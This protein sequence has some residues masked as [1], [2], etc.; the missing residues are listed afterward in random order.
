M[1]VRLWG[2]P[3]TVNQT[4]AGFQMDPDVAT[5]ADG[6]TI[7]VWEDATGADTRIMY[8]L[9]NSDGTPAGSEVVV[10][11]S[12]GAD[13]QNPVVT[14]L[15]NGGWAIGYDNSGGTGNDSFR[16]YNAAG[17]NLSSSVV[18]SNLIN[19]YPEIINVGNEYWAISVGSGANNTITAFRFNADSGISLGGA[20]VQGV[21]TGVQRNPA[22]TQLLN[23]DV[24]I[25]WRDQTN[26]EFRMFNDAGVALTVGDRLVAN[27]AVDVSNDS[28]G[29]P[30][31]LALENGGFLITWT[32]NASPFP[33][34]GFDV[35]GQMY[36]QAGSIIGSTF[37]MNSTVIDNQFNPVT[38]ALKNGGFA[39]L[40]GTNA[41]SNQDI[42]G[43]IFDIGGTRIGTEF[44]VSAGG[45]QVD[46]DNLDATLLE[47]GRILVSWTQLNVDGSGTAIVNQII[48]PRNGSITGDTTD[49]TLY[50]GNSDDV[51][52]ASGGDDTVI[53]MDG[54]DQVFG[55]VGHDV[56]SGG[57]DNDEIYGSLGDDI[58]NG[59]DG[60][61][62]L[63]GG[64][65]NDVIDGGVG[66][67][68]ASYESAVAGVNIYLMFSG[69]DTLGSGIDTLLNIENLTGSTHDDRLIADGNNNVLT[70]GDGADVLKGKGGNDIFYGGN[71]NDKMVGGSGNDTMF[72]GAGS[73]TM[74]ALG[75]LDILNG[76]DGDDFLF[77]GQDNDTLNGDA[78]NDNIR[79][80]LGTDVINGGAGNDTLRGGGQN[81]ALNGGDGNDFLFGE[82]HS[83][84]LFGGAGD[85]VL[86]GGSGGGVADAFADTF[87]YKSAADGGGGFD[88][89]KDFDNGTDVIDLRSF[90]YAGFGNVLSLAS[91]AGV[92]MRL[93]FG[94]GEVL[95]IENFQL[96]D[97]D[98]SD[99]LI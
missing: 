12:S 95:Y 2:G 51:I 70:G 31:V 90:G 84:I 6:R 33:G 77:G 58:L 27:G 25:V 39:L 4:T 37:L 63:V 71:G 26:I 28:W 47:D 72:G 30:D 34:F 87:V 41:G 65:G 56:L 64:L 85:D 98:I 16:F 5:L 17:I 23:S 97:F 53:A 93:D 11:I 13:L 49:N 22:G 8:R 7:V 24:V 67:D 92:N 9:F 80:N 79:G 91:D 46:F 76:G 44:T 86:N 48:D 66:I 20:S 83:D 69:V 75:G 43:Q 88:R 38:V 68:T 32:D 60:D 94:G 15:D 21:T 36:D 62:Y 89:I 81:D 18:T 40:Y 19:S 99:V 10:G 78:G 57:G 82:N 73:D 35:W 96:V 42:R 14:A 54:K 61:D 74:I 50:G 59:D 45:A 1:P 52:M 29:K 3:V 55:G